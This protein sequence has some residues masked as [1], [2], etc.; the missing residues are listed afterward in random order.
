MKIIAYK[1]RWE[2]KP[3][4]RPEG[5]APWQ[6]VVD[7]GGEWDPGHLADV[8]GPDWLIAYVTP[9][10]GGLAAITSQMTSDGHAV[11]HPISPAALLAKCRAHEPF[12]EYDLYLDDDGR[13][14]GFPTDTSPVPW[15][16]T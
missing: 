16:A 7:N 1:L 2:T 5:F 4:R 14:R 3:G 11:A 15:E 12:S 6:A 10:P 8:W 13:V 9:G